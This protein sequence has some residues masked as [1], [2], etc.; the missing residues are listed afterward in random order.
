MKL[1]TVPKQPDEVKDRDVMLTRY[2][3]NRPGDEL[4]EAFIKSI[5]PAGLN[6]RLDPVMAD[7]VKVWFSDGEHDVTYKVEVT[8][9]TAMGRVIEGEI[10]VTVRE[11]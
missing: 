1:G 2:F 8:L 6:V 11:L 10:Y 3:K 7:H 5:D 9:N 4:D